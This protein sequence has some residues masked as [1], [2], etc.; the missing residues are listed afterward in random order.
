MVVALPGDRAN[1]HSR[2]TAIVNILAALELIYTHAAVERVRGYE[3]NGDPE[4]RSAV[5]ST[6]TNGARM[7]YAVV[8]ITRYRGGSITRQTLE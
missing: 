6:R 3:N 4:N 7:A 1:L 2:R 5:E 8:F